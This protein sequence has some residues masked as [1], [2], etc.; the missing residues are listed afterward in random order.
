M[1]IANRQRTKDIL[2]KHNIKLKKSLGQNFLTDNNILDKI[3]AEANLS[4]EDSVI[5]VGPGIGAL[6]ERMSEAAKEVVAVELDNRLIPVLNEIFE[7][8]DNVSI[9]HGDALE[10]DFDSLIDGDY[11]VVANLPYYITT[12]IIMR[13]LE[14]SSGAK[15]IVVMVQKEVGERMVASPGGKDYGILSIAVQ[16]YTEAEIA[17]GVPSSVFIP[18]PKVDSAIVSLK[19]LDYPRAKVEDEDFFFKVVKSAFHQRRKTVRNSLSKAPFLSVPRDIIDQA[20]EEVEID[21][22]RRAEKISVEKFIE[23]SNAIY[24]IY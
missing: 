5:E 2:Q 15:E 7:E 4:S 21:P 1:K 22:R 16:Y 14:E 13:F 6:T 9:I 18:R 11:K 24:R 10:V 8:Q 12:P 19:V 17:F 3:V 23:L 20:L